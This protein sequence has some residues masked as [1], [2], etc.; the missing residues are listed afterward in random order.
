MCNIAAKRNKIIP[1]STD[2]IDVEK[3]HGSFF[4]TEGWNFGSNQRSLI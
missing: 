2:I 1:F 4:V 3:Y